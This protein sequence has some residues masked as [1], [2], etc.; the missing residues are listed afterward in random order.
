[1]FV[2]VKE[3]IIIRQ[4]VNSQQECLRTENIP[5]H[6]HSI[7]CVKKPW[8]RKPLLCTTL[9]ALQEEFD[10]C[11]TVC[12]QDIWPVWE[13]LFVLFHGQLYS[14]LTSLL[15]YERIS[16]SVLHDYSKTLRVKTKDFWG[17][18]SGNIW[19]MVRKIRE[20]KVPKWSAWQK[21]RY[22]NGSRFSLDLFSFVFS[23]SLFSKK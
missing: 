8:F 1:M 2:W 9:H 20:K 6:I 5:S 12:L 3:I 21:C 4:R 16:Q 15:V 13:W 11:M 18:K 22:L 17:F 19:T 10:W 7:F 14:T 23:D